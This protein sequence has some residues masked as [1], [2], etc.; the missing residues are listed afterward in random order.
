MFDSK[1]PLR[2]SLTGINTEIVTS[3]KDL[4]N[5]HLHHKAT[6][7]FAEEKNNDAESNTIPDISEIIDIKIKNSN[8]LKTQ[9]LKQNYDKLATF[10][11]ND[12]ESIMNQLN[13]QEK[14]AGDLDSQEDVKEKDNN[15]SEENYPHEKLL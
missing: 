15:S 4:K 3:E 14:N 1:S 7:I 9:N 5:P 10:G 12:Q 8:Y 13:T 11:F 6:G 2:P